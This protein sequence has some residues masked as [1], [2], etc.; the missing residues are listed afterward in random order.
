MKYQRV[1]TVGLISFLSFAIGWAAAFH[2][3]ERN[4]RSLNAGYMQIL[5]NEKA[6]ESN[7][8][9]ALA[10]CLQTFSEATV[11]YDQVSDPSGSIPLFHGT[12]NLSI[13]LAGSTGQ[14][15]QPRW[16]IPAK[17]QPQAMAAHMVYSYWNPQTG[18]VSSAMYASDP[19]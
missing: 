15:L 1:A 6:Q 5:M 12:V 14:K 19:K 3:A 2:I 11:L 9:K 13:S 18:A 4:L 7:Q 10:D 16:V 17:I 8:T